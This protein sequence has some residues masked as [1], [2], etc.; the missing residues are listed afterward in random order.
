M[1]YNEIWN[2]MEW[3]K[4]YTAKDLTISPAS[5]LAMERRG[6]VKKVAVKPNRYMKQRN[7][8]IDIAKIVEDKDVY[9]TVWKVGKTMGMMCRF[10]NNSIVDCWDKPYDVSGVNRVLY[11]G[12]EVELYE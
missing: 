8:A 6:M 12:K 5:M 10:K 4:D 1:D 11:K 7:T 9:F 3:N 2:K